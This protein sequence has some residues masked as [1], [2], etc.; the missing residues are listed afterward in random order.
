MKALLFVHALNDRTIADVAC[1]LAE[2]T[3]AAGHDVALAAAIV[4]R[5]T[6]RRPVDVELMDLGQSTGG[7][8]RSI[9]PLRRAIVRYRP[10]VIFAHGSGPARASVV[11]TRTVTPRPTVI[12]VE[13]NHYSSYAWSHR[14]VRFLLD[15]ML[16][17]RADWV[18]GV[19]PEIVTDLEMTF[20]ALR[21]RTTY[22]PPPLTRWRHLEQLANEPITHPWFET[23]GDIV[24]SVA[25]IHARKDPETLVRAVIQ[26]NQ[27][28]T[29]PLRLVVIGRPMDAQ[30]HLRL[31]SLVEATGMTERIQFL[32][33]IQNPLP[34]VR[35][36][37][38]FALTSRNEGLPISLLEAM[39]LGTPV[40]STDCPSG[41]R[42][43][44]EEGRVGRLVPVG[45]VSAVANTLEGLIDDQRERRRLAQ[46]A[47]RRVADFKPDRVAAEYLHLAS[48][49]GQ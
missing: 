35:K 25:N 22:I 28:R 41:P 40:V 44:L 31:E 48:T 49:L 26:A 16:V 20:S 45:D 42:F 2:E 37:T 4:E 3:R 34:Y 10:Q 1:T 43:L 21:G 46:A 12:A 30:L 23:P 8:W 7:S 27:R 29:R 39:A 9:L 47:A 38:L 5:R 14:K 33:F 17:P 6:V 18:V 32:G 11:A 19:A 13:H 15:S 36:A 24:V